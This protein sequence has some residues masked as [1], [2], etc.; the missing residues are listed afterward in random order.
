[1]VCPSETLRTR[2]N[3]SEVILSGLDVLSETHRAV[4][5]Q[6]FDEQKQPDPKLFEDFC[7]YT[8]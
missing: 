6:V 3:N 5:K 2:W 4:S 7:D 8:F 1:M